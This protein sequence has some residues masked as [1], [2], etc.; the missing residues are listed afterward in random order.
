M[1]VCWKR[2]AGRDQGKVKWRVRWSLIPLLGADFYAC[3]EMHNNV[4]TWCWYTNGKHDQCKYRMYCGWPQCH[5]HPQKV[6]AFKV[7]DFLAQNNSR[8][9]F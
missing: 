7:N 8:G 5:E 9:N 3:G 2:G 4:R 6:F 1:G